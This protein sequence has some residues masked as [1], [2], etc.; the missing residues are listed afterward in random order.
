MPFKDALDKQKIEIVILNRAAVG[1]TINVAALTVY[2]VSRST[3][4]IYL[5]Y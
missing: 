3:N 1:H 4:L 5:K 2:D